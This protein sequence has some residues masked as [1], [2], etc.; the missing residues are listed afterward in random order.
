MTSPV[1]TY[2]SYMP[3][4]FTNT[5]ELA[6]TVAAFTVIKS[7]MICSI[8]GSALWYTGEDRWK[9]ITL[10]IGALYSSYVGISVAAYAVD[11]SYGWGWLQS[12]H[13]VAFE[14][15]IGETLETASDIA[16]AVALTA[17]TYQVLKAM[18]WNRYVQ[19]PSIYLGF[20]ALESLPYQL[21][22]AF[23]F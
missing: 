18:A 11:A 21:I 3:D 20:L 6:K 9:M 2:P 7:S 1:T 15:D 14:D 16:S 12:Q 17:F 22:R 10:K 19:Y 23:P 8:G 5:W 13:H 4:A